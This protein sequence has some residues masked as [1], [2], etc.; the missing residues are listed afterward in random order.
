MKPGKHLLFSTVNS[1]PF[2]SLP[3]NPVTTVITYFRFIRP[4]LFKMAGS[5]NF[6]LPI[7]F[8]ETSEDIQRNKERLEFV[9]GKM[10]TNQNGKTIAIPSSKRESNMITSLCNANIL[11]HVEPG[12]IPVMKGTKLKCELLPYFL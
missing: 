8:L 9:R 6:E 1:T 10:S 3:G 2:F 7:I 5:S 12:N 11:I 4:F